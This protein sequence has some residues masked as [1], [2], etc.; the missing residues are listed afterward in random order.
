M[1]LF[2]QIY[3]NIFKY[4]STKFKYVVLKGTYVIFESVLLFYIQIKNIKI[5]RNSIVTKFFSFKKIQNYLNHSPTD[6]FQLSITQKPSGLRPSNQDKWTQYI[7]K[8]KVLYVRCFGMVH[9]KIRR[10]DVESALP[11]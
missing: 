7:S 9:G 5:Y 1:N 4:V 10:N 8:H 11:F 3:G 2:C 6:N